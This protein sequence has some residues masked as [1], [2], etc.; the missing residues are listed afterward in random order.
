[1]PAV[2]ELVVDAGQIWQDPLAV[3]ELAAAQKYN[4]LADCRLLVFDWIPKAALPVAASR[5][6]AAVDLLQRPE[7]GGV[8]MEE[9]RQGREAV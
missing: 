4:Q 2:A 3:L 7:V 5:D 6:A 8:A 1:M 9:T